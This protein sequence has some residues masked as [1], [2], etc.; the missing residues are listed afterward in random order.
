MMLQL[1]A[2]QNE[3]KSDFLYRNM[4]L[5]TVTSHM[6]ALKLTTTPCR[7][8]E[9][10]LILFFFLLRHLEAYSLS[11]PVGLIIRNTVWRSPS[12][13]VCSDTLPLR[14]RYTEPVNF[15]HQSTD[16]KPAIIH[17]GTDFDRLFINT[18]L[19]SL[20]L[21]ERPDFY[22]KNM[23][24]SD[25]TCVHWRLLFTHMSSMLKGKKTKLSLI[26]STSLTPHR[27][28]HRFLNSSSASLYLHLFVAHQPTVAGIITNLS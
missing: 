23:E 4:R 25:I 20:L 21:L 6:E 27:E 19:K 13:H 18:Q 26:W 1:G 17:S 15:S 16:D 9:K 7:Q 5:L 2:T 22:L 14:W 8:E 28:A 24:Y 10:R 12:F 11:C 3:H